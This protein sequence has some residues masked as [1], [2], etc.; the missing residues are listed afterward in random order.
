MTDDRHADLEAT[1]TRPRRPPRELSRVPAVPEHL[2]PAGAR[3]GRAGRGRVAG[4]HG[5]ARPASSTSRSPRPAAIRSSTATGSTPRA[6]RPSSCTATTTSSRS[7]RSTCGRR[8]RS[9]RS[10]STAGCSLAVPADDKGQIHAHLMAAAGDPATRG[11]LPGQR[12]VRV[13]GRGGEARR[14]NLAAGWRPTAT[15]WRRTSR[16]SAT[17]ASSRATSRRSRSA[18]AG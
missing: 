13:R 6:P 16:S 15:A 4:R 1:S 5:C 7:I 2:G 3:P 12:A 18:C 11:G 14:S 17:P 8:R 9:S 10:S